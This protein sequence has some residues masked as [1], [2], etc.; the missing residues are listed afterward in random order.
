MI[1]P[2]CSANNDRV[3]DSRSSEGGSAIRR[4]RI[5]N[6]CEKR[7]TTYER[8]ER[9]VKLMVVK[10]DGRHEPFNQHKIFASIEAAC[11]KLP[12]GIDVIQ[13]IV[14]DIE[15]E[16]HREFEREIS[17]HI[18]GERVASRLHK[19]DKVAYVRFA[20]VYKHFRDLDELAEEIHNAR[21]IA[22][23]EVPGQGKLFGDEST[24]TDK[25]NG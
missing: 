14:D 25:T 18:I 10:A 4:R 1:C 22:K 2:F 24:V 21:D 3:I 16:L 8:V 12:I 9:I 23:A 20:S 15:D 5:C 13:Q 6:K 11:G 17:S 7:F 19:I